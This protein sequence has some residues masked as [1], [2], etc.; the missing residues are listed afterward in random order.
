MSPGY[1]TDKSFSHDGTNLKRRPWVETR[2]FVQSDLQQVF[3]TYSSRV[4][5]SLPPPPQH[6]ALGANEMAWAKRMFLV[7]ITT[8]LDC[9]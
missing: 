5:E 3:T 6:L 2:V 9:A 7:I 4:R 8:A 1:D